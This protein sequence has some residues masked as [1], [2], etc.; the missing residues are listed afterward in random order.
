MLS[1]NLVKEGNEEIDTIVHDKV[2]NRQALATA[3]NKVTLGRK[4]KEESEKELQSLETKMK[5]II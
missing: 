4:R 2:L 3:N 5:N 1:E